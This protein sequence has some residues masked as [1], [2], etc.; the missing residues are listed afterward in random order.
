M[1]QFDALRQRAKPYVDA[2][3][4]LIGSGVHAAPTLPAS[5][6][7]DLPVIVRKTGAG[8]SPDAR[9]SVFT[10][11]IKRVVNDELE[12]K[13]Q[14]I[15][16]ALFALGKYA[17]IPASERRHE[18]LRIYYDEPHVNY[19]RWNE[20]Y[21]KEPRDRLLMAVYNKLVMAGARAE[22]ACNISMQGGGAMNQSDL[23]VDPARG[24]IFRG[25]Y[26]VE[27]YEQYYNLPPGP[28][29]PRETL[30]IRE[31]VSLRDNVEAFRSTGRWWGKSVEQLPDITL[32]GPGTLSIIDDHPLPHSQPARVFVTE[33]R[34][35][36]PLA[37]NE[38]TRFALLRRH[39]VPYEELVRTDFRDSVGLLQVSAPIGYAS[40]GVRFPLND[41]PSSVWHYEDLPDYLL[42]GVATEDS[43]LSLDESGFVQFSWNQPLVG[44][45]YGIGWE[46]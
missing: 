10:E 25:G 13:D 4:S 28:G 12:G 15:A 40:V 8:S 9:A 38:R 42:P 33:V 11:E 43:A 19:G 23:A 45:C 1:E 29:K 36:Q 35:P 7:I 39:L 41:R 24:R 30:Q 22:A 31:L 18:V 3:A 37:R 21:R 34:F 6:L 16:R 27:R 20:S 2:L 44:Y 32:Y 26:K 46:W 14:E 17:G 5:V